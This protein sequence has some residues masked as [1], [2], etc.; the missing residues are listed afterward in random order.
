LRQEWAMAYLY[1]IAK[2]RTKIKILI[3]FSKR[4][5]GVSHWL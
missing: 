5:R 3:D 1:V 4:I 2:Y